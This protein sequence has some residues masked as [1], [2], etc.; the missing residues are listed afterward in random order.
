MIPRFVALTLALF[1]VQ[2]TRLHAQASEQAKQLAAFRLVVN[3]C[4][5]EVKK[6]GSYNFDMY[7]T[8]AGELRGWGNNHDFYLF[9]RC[10]KQQ[11]Y[12]TQVRGK[13]DSGR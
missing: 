5:K 13:K 1:L 10:M 3:D 2:P 4:V 8:K 9:N 11:G 6:E 7:V 12:D